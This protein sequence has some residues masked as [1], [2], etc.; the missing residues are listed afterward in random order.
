[1]VLCE[2]AAAG[3][4]EQALDYSGL[5]NMSAALVSEKQ[6]F[7]SQGEAWRCLP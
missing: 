1:M 5:V 2:R 4:C 3:G 7:K 6:T